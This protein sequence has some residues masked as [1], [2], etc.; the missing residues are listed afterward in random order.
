M[1]S[2][3]RY[4]KQQYQAWQSA[5]QAI[6]DA[7]QARE[8]LHQA[9]AAGHPGDIQY[10]RG[11]LEDALQ[12]VMQT[13]CYTS[14]YINAESQENLQHAEEA[15]AADYQLLLSNDISDLSDDVKDED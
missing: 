6:A 8:I 2:F 7:E 10:A 4:Q 11:Q 9:L 13:R 12:Q 14:G 5:R 1:N 15:L 3:D